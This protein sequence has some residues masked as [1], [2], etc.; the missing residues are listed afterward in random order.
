M[1]LGGGTGTAVSTGGP[2]PEGCSPNPGKPDARQG[3]GPPPHPDL[4]PDEDN[5]F[6]S[7]EEWYR[8]KAEREPG[9]VDAVHRAALLQVLLPYP[10]THAFD[11]SWKDIPGQPR[12]QATVIHTY[13]GMIAGLPK[14]YRP[15]AVWVVAEPHPTSGRWHAHGFWAMEPDALWDG[16][17]RGAKEYLG[18]TVGWARIWP[19]HASTPVELAT[20][21]EYPAKHAVKRRP[22]TFWDGMAVISIA[23]DHEAVRRV[24]YMWRGHRVF[25][26]WC[27]GIL[28][29]VAKEA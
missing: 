26:V 3:G 18:E 1:Q 19:F 23:S 5:P 15:N 6:I 17:W 20:R 14:E 4:P 11:Q 9:V 10:W 27:A 16:W 12:G 13:A 7:R 24:R 25:R 2:L 29:P 21:L 28:S 22:T 8:W